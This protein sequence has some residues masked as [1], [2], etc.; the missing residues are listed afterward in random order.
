MKFVGADGIR[1]K[2]NVADVESISVLVGELDR[3]GV[4]HGGQFRMT[5]FLSEG[6]PHMPLGVLAITAE[7]VNA[8]SMY[9][10]SSFSKNGIVGETF[11]NESTGG[12]HPIDGMV[13]GQTQRAGWKAFDGTN[14]NVVMATGL[15]HRT[16]DQPPAL[17][18]FGPKEP[19]TTLL[20]RLNEPERPEA[21][22]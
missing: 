13:D 3:G 11:D 12:T 22:E 17:A 14:A 15:L 18:H 16:Q 9:R 10:Q 1:M 4:F 8:S 19:Q 5:H 6:H 7:G 20:V 2:R 21:G